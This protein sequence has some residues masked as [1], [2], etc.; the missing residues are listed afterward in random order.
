MPRLTNVMRAST[1][2]RLMSGWHHIMMAKKV[3]DTYVW[4]EEH[5]A[6]VQFYND[7]AWR[8]YAQDKFE[9]ARLTSRR[10]VE[11][12][13][14]QQTVICTLGPIHIVF[15]RG[16]NPD[17]FAITVPHMGDIVLTPLD[18]TNRL[19]LH[20]RL[21]TGTPYQ[22][23]T[24][25]SFSQCSEC[26][27][28]NAY[29]TNNGDDLLCESCEVCTN[30]CACRT[31]SLCDNRITATNESS[32][33]GGHC[34]ACC[35]CR[36]GVPFVKQVTSL[37]SRLKQDTL[38]NRLKTGLRRLVACEIEVAGVGECGRA[39]HSAIANA[40]KGWGGEIV[41][42]GSLPSGGFEINT[43]PAS[44]TLFTKQIQEVVAS[45]SNADAFVTTACGLHVHVDARD[46]T[47][48]DLRRLALLWARVEPALMQM[49]PRSRRSNS[50]CQ[51]ARS[52]FLR[53]EK[54]TTKE[55]TAW[56]QEGVGQ[57]NRKTA[58][59]VAKHRKYD[60]QHR[61]FAL[62]LYSWLVR[63]TVE[64]RLGAGSTNATKIINWAMLTSSLVDFAVKN[65]DKV[66][67]GLPAHD[68]GAEALPV[69]YSVAPK[70]LHRWIGRRFFSNRAVDESSLQIPTIS[71]IIYV[72]ELP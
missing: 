10:D 34:N 40:V 43:C 64:N 71:P 18:M 41:P 35:E 28:T 37:E 50:Y 7:T 65:P 56:L 5:P 36:T 3:G 39:D 61:R 4:T 33:G 8:I 1:L 11:M 25:V 72:P 16:R 66:I 67:Q 29:I 49:S 60:S 23:H 52:E 46:L 48:S 30:C 53:L 19:G 62:N 20:V 38:A 2:R 45:L 54:M 42:D 58:K 15:E 6:S 69:L 27:A 68:K 9:V 13:S 26:R 47:Y 57:A 17:D 32:C 12:A 51:S 70:A 24:G 55:F 44:G 63:G 21:D 31:C 59:S 22:R 14:Q